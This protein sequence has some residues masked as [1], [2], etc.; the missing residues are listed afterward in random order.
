MHQV[1]R[2]Q[3]PLTLRAAEPV[4]L[5]GVRLH[6]VQCVLRLNQCPKDAVPVMVDVFLPGPVLKFPALLEDSVKGLPSILYADGVPT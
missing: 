3:R 5:E 6:Q 2:F 1:H 4:T